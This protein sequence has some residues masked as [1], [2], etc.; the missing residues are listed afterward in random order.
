MTIYKNSAYSSEVDYLTSALDGLSADAVATGAAINNSVNRHL[1]MAVQAELSQ[2]DLSAQS[3]PAVLVRLIKS[4]DGG[5]TFEDND[6]KA[7]ALTLPVAQT[8]AAHKRIGELMI[9]PGQ[10]KLAV[11]NKTG[12]AFAASG[13][14]L[15]YVTYTPESA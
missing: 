15:S 4:I 7:Y 12:T 13:N 8:N 2:V 14:V 6:D 5:T 9:P 10:F 1:F 11:V 3:G